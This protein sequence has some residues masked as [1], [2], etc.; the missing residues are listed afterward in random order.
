M[1]TLDINVYSG[2]VNYGS[3]FVLSGIFSD[4]YYLSGL[5]IN[6]V[7]YTG[8]N[9]A[10]SISTC[11]FS[12]TYILA[13][14][15]HTFDLT[16]FDVSDNTV[17]TGITIFVDLYDRIPDSISFTTQTNVDRSTVTTSNT[18]TISGIEVPV[19]ITVSGG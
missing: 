1:P 15:Y 14:G 8:C 19:D 10:G 6:N 4:G 18:V 2:Y 11:N 16:G 5:Y 9:F 12:K 3:S 13:S 17:T 7:A